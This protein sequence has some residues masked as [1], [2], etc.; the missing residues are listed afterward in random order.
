MAIRPLPDRRREPNLG[1]VIA[2]HIADEGKPSGNWTGV[3]ALP[4]EM[5]DIQGDLLTGMKKNCKRAS[6]IVLK[7]SK[8][9]QSAWRG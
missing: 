5:H 7:F 4:L 9:T 6:G 8:A 2:G 1:R 3:I